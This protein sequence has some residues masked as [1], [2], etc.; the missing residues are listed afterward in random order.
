MLAWLNAGLIKGAHKQEAH[1]R[2]PGHPAMWVIDPASVTARKVDPLAERV[3]ALQQE[4]ATL[5]RRLERLNAPRGTNTPLPAPAPP[6]ASLSAL[7]GHSRSPRLHESAGETL[8]HREG[9]ARWLVAHGL[10][11]TSTAKTWPE[12]PSGPGLYDKRQILQ[13]ALDKQRYER[14]SAK[15]WSLVRCSDSTCVCR[16][17]L[18]A[19]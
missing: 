7:Q 9:A 19:D 12:F 11:S 14:R 3:A 1:E 4:V 18:P 2:Q 6:V 16:E 13:I 10:R 17:L 5:R 15:I 8:P